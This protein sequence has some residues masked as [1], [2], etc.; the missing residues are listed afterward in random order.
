MSVT[1]RRSLW[2][3]V[4]L[5]VLV[6]L[7][8]GGAVLRSE[9]QSETRPTASST[10][11]STEPTTSPSDS[12]PAPQ[13]EEQLVA[14]A[15]E[16]LDE[17]A[18]VAQLF[19]V[20]VQLDDLSSGDALAEEGMGGLFMA[21]RSEAPATELA[22][23][24][25]RW[26][27]MAPGPAL[28]VA[29]D[30]EGGS[31]QTFKGPGFD[32]LPSAVEQGA[33]PPAELAAT[34]RTMGEQLASAGVNLNLAP[35]VDVV[36]AGSEAGNAPIGAFDRQY[37]GTAPVVEAAAGTVMD[38]LADAGVTATLKHFPGL[39]R[40]SSNTDT[41]AAVIDRS[42]TADDEQVATFGS[43]AASPAHPFVMMSS[44]TY[45]RIDPDHQA[46]FSRIVLTDLLRGR[47][48]FDGV[49]LTDDVGNAEA[50]QDVD[51]GERAVRFLE[52]G[53]T[54]VLTV[55]PSIVPDMIDAVLARSAADPQFADQVDAAVTTAL[56]AK[57]RAG[58]LD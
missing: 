29:A 39:G 28:W 41:S 18:R 30:Q 12:A 54:M 51:A 50:V 38:G 23:T 47:L 16:A 24:T 53:G 19:L 9:P 52:A 17:R 2:A 4:I 25:A 11:T 7:V 34:A 40:V 20:G 3:A 15:L 14:A 32:R 1:A 58:L 37:G 44:A 56:T 27:S 21:G 55:E 8:V 13:P 36:P 43:L 10:S 31:V 22:E 49:V 6:A 35:V 45:Q 57:A 26:Q 5:A 48:G 46:A 42:T 33:M